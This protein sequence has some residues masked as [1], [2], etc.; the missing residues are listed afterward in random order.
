[1]EQKGAG[2]KRPQTDKRPTLIDV[3]RVAGVSLGTASRVLNGSTDVKPL[4]VAKVKKAMKSLNYRPSDVARS[5]RTNTSRMIGCMVTDITQ[6]VSGAMVGGAEEVLWRAGYALI[7]TATHQIVERE[8]SI[9]DLFAR[10]KLEGMILCTTRDADASEALDEIVDRPLVLWERDGGSRFDMVLTEHGR[11]TELAANHLIGLGHKRIALVSGYEGTWTGREQIRGYRNAMGAAKLALPKSA[12]HETGA[13]DLARAYELLN[14]PDRP[15]AVILNVND[16]AVFLQAARTLRLRVPDDISIV[17]IGDN[18]ELDVYSPA[19]TA[20]RGDGR[21]VG[22]EA[23]RL[24][25]DR[26]QGAHRANRRVFI[27]TEL[28]VRH[29]TAAPPR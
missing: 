17:S 29:S 15:T 21:K 7:V 2:S 27:P 14:R 10:H 20:V 16:A 25:L 3:A 12:L 23:A 24:L 19:V 4:N 11:G 26:I 18:P 1:M 28:I 5:M 22:S 9:L 8:R 6:P 13:F